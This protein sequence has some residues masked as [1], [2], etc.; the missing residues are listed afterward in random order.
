MVSPMTRPIY[1]KKEYTVSITQ[2]KG[3]TS[4]G[5]STFRRKMFV[6]AWNQTPIR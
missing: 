4:G 6:P 1:S 5:G 2:D 3:K